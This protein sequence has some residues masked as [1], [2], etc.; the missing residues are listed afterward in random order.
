MATAKQIQAV[1]AYEQTVLSAYTDLLNQLNKLNNYSKSFD[2][3]T[4]EVDILNKSV[5]IANS[6]YRNARAD[7]V[8]VLLTQEEVLDAKMELMETRLEQLQAKG[9]LPHFGRWLALNEL[10]VLRTALTKSRSAS[11]PVKGVTPLFLGVSSQYRKSKMI[12]NLNA[13][14]KVSMDTRQV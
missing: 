6:L 5:S 1:Y 2:T 14:L 12:L 4:A 13:F 7:Y 9:Y 10:L 11:F 3:K 8:E